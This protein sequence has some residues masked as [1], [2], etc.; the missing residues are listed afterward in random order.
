MRSAALAV[1]LA[2]LSAGRAA[3]Q[4]PGLGLDLTA[5]EPEVKPEAKPSEPKPPEPPAP[6]PEEPR[7][8][9]KPAPPVELTERDVALED[10]VKSVQRKATLKRLRLELAPAVGIS[11]NDP[12][13][14]KYGAGLWVLAYPNDSLGVG[15][16][17]M[18]LTSSPTENVRIAQRDLLALLP[19]SKPAYALA[20]DVQWTAF[21][22]KVSVLNA[23]AQFDLFLVGGP[24]A[25]VSQTTGSTGE[26]HFGAD[27]G[28]GVRAMVGDFL[29]VHITYLDTVYSDRPGGQ[30][31]SQLHS[32]GMLQVGLCVF[33]PPRF[34]YEVH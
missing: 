30:S 8:A 19:V 12:F 6:P 13:Y 27:L 24:A 25:V 21:Y 14:T 18:A 5:P 31:R 7:P 26:I 34:E 17:G 28:L 1:T 16:R 23:I 22:G 9:E 4:D 10:R 32:L 15:L 3:A 20:V 33:V 2:I 29:A 11:L